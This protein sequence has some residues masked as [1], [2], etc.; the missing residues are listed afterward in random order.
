LIWGWNR[1]LPDP[2]AAA[3]ILNKQQGKPD[4]ELPSSLRTQWENVQAPPRRSKKR[5]TK[6]HTGQIKD[7]LMGGIGNAHKIMAGEHDGKKPI[8]RSRCRWEDNITQSSGKNYRSVGG[9]NCYW[10]SPVQSFLV[11][12]PAGLTTTCSCGKRR[13]QQFFL[14]LRVY[15]LR[16]NLAVT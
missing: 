15:S 1:R 8:G 13:V 7:G 11:P 6:C 14:L 5:G 2:E 9:V 4:K 3:N 10:P 12:S 16:S